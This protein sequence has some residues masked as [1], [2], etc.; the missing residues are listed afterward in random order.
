[1][2]PTTISDVTI[3]YRA[4]Y[5][6]LSDVVTRRFGWAICV[7]HERWVP[8][9]YLQIRY[10][11]YLVLQSHP[12]SV[13]LRNPI[14]I[15][16][17]HIDQKYFRIIGGGPVIKAFLCRDNLAIQNATWILTAPLLNIGVALSRSPPHVSRFLFLPELARPDIK[18]TTGYA[19]NE[20]R[21]E[22]TAVNFFSNDDLFAGNKNIGVILVRFD[23]VDRGSV[24]GSLLIRSAEVA[25]RIVQPVIRR[26]TLCAPSIRPLYRKTP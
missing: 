6:T 1:M 4:D 22:V 25:P 12:L 17:P 14:P 18:F 5:T 16:E 7:L 3:W 13:G 19:G 9:T 8:V 26:A 20:D 11:L 21:A 15:W 24:F 10:P 2:C 23:I